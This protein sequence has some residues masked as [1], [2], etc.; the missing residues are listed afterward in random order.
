MSGKS[1]KLKNVRQKK[2]FSDAIINDLTFLDGDR[3][4]YFSDSVPFIGLHQN[5][6]SELVSNDR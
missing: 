5:K 4:R 6:G 3:K 2:R 1:R